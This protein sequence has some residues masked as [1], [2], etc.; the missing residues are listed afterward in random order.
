MFWFSGCL[1]SVPQMK[2]ISTS[3]EERRKQAT[4]IVLLGVIGA[5]FGAEIEPPKLLTR[6]LANG[7]YEEPGSGCGPTSLLTVSNYPVKLLGRV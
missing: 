2:K 1:S 4:A 6:R 5:E 3:Y 7:F